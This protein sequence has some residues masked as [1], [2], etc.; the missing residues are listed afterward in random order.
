MIVVLKKSSNNDVYT[1][2]KEFLSLILQDKLFGGQN[3][4]KDFVLS[5]TVKYVNID[6]LFHGKAEEKIR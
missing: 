3:N 4:C 1:L 2:I 5:N 6:S